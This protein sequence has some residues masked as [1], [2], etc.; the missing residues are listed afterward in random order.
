MTALRWNCFGATYLWLPDSE[1]KTQTL[2]MLINPWFKNHCTVNQF[3]RWPM[4][5]VQETVGSGTSNIRYSYNVCHTTIESIQFRHTYQTKTSTS[6]S[7]C[8]VLFFTKVI[9]KLIELVCFWFFFWLNLLDTK[10]SL[11]HDCPPLWDV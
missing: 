11:S 5:V 3:A 2:C 10:S 6:T 7:F 9:Q 1:K 4:R 8:F